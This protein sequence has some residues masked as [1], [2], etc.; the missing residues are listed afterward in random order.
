MVS[1]F[2]S[3]YLVKNVGVKTNGFPV[4]LGLQLLNLEC[5]SCFYNMR[6][7]HTEKVKT[8][9]QVFLIPYW[10]VGSA[11]SALGRA[12]VDLQPTPQSV[13]LHVY[14]KTI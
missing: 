12:R 11:C 1:Y 6:S 14:E 10:L 9:S 13:P 8:R 5:M 3:T 2:R 7:T 4:E